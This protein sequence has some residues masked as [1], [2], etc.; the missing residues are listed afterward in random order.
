MKSAYPT[1][2]Q[3]PEINTHLVSLERKLHTPAQ[4]E[5]IES[6]IAPLK[7]KHRHTVD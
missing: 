3:Q 5:E 1:F 2:M 6:Y 7:E 4:F